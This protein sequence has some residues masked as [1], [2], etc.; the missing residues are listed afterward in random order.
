MR[1]TTHYEAQLMLGLAFF[2]KHHTT[3]H[4]Y[5]GE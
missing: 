3:F 2:V 1:K 5:T 4:R